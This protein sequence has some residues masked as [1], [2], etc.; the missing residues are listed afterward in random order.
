MFLSERHLD[1]CFNLQSW[2]S[3]P[4]LPTSLIVLLCW[5]SQGKWSCWGSHLYLLR[6]SEDI[7]SDHIVS[8]FSWQFVENRVRWFGDS[9]EWHRGTSLEHI[10]RLQPH[11]GSGDPCRC[12]AVGQSGV[13]TTRELAARTEVSGP[14]ARLK[15]RG[16]FFDGNFVA[17]RGLSPRERSSHSTSKDIL[18]RSN[19]EKDPHHTTT[20]S[21]PRERHH[22]LRL[23]ANPLPPTSQASSL[24]N[25]APPN[26]RSDGRRR[27][28]Q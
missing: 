16:S 3:T 5:G 14:C 19:C 11:H 28:R 25:R 10:T 7:K 17:N 6:Y 26:C 4:R 23:T 24:R 21:T 13:G 8:A 15:W 12:W 20:N 1:A 9:G 18:R 22:F 27:G 2:G